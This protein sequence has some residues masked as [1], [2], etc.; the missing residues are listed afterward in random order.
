MTEQTKREIV[1]SFAYGMDAKEVSTA[2][3]ISFEE[4]GK[5]AEEHSAEITEKKHQLNREGWM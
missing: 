4:S 2:Y 3:G 5:F 1:K